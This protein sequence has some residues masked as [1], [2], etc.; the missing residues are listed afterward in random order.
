MQRDAQHKAA[1]QAQNDAMM[2]DEA[3]N[4]ANRKKPDTAAILDAA[5]QAGKSGG[6]STMLTGPGGSGSLGGGNT[7]LGG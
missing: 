3:R 7:L 2:S 1:V 5:M 4:R 6:N